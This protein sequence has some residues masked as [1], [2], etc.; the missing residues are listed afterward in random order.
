MKNQVGYKSLFDS[1][2]QSFIQ[3]FVGFTDAEGCFLIKL[4]RNKVQPM[5]QI[6]L[7]IDDLPLLEY[8]KT[9]LACGYISSNTEENKANFT[10]SSHSALQGILL[11]IFDSFQLNTTKYLNYLAFREVINMRTTKDH[12]TPEGWARILCL[13]AS[14]NKALQSLICLPTTWSISPGTGC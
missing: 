6:G 12:L 1:L 11:P 13:K 7:H 10:I 2:D 5:F 14:M 3:W 9:K 8:L 4:S